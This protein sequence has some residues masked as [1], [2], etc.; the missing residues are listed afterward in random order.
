MRT[1]TDIRKDKTMNRYNHT[2][3]DKATLQFRCAYCEEQVKDCKC[4][5]EHE[6]SPA[7][8]CPFCGEDDFDKP[9]LKYHIETYCEQYKNI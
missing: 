6:L 8:F 7:T 1:H 3:T 2:N 9:G 5:L 4:H